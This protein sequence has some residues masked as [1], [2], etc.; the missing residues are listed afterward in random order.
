MIAENY[1]LGTPASVTLRLATR[2]ASHLP[3]SNCVMHSPLSECLRP[4]KAVP[5]RLGFDGK[6]LRSR[7]VPGG[8]V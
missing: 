4:L 3:Q 8:T 7:G 5:P 1:N 6:L 2:R